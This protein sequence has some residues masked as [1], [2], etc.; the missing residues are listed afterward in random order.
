MSKKAHY[1]T[2]KRVTSLNKKSR[3]MLLEEECKDNTNF[4][5]AKAVLD[6]MHTP[7]D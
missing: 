4:I 7:R 2:N 1:F 3:C 5:A 6:G